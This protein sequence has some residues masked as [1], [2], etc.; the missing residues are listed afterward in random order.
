MQQLGVYAD[1]GEAVDLGTWLQ[2]YAFDVVGE[3]SFATKLGFL[4]KGKDGDGMMA[5]I[6]GLLVSALIP[7]SKCLTFLFY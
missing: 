5:A 7:K 1:R 3:L 2:Y 6:S 4:E